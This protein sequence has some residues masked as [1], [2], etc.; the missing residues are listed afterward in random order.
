LIVLGVT[1]YSYGNSGLRSFAQ[2]TALLG[3]IFMVWI[4][5]KALVFGMNGD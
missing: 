2:V 1:D 4:A 3:G 5:F